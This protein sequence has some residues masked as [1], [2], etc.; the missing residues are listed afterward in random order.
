MSDVAL[1]WVIVDG[2]AR[3]VSEFAHIPVRRRPQARCPECDRPLTLKLGDVRRHHAAHAPD[4]I[5]AATQPETARHIAAKFGLAERLR[6]A[7][8][9]S[10]VLRIVQHCAGG[11]ANSDAC[12]K[13]N[14]VDWLNGWDEVQVER[15]VSETLRPDIVLQRTG[16]DVGAI[17]LLVTHAVPAEKIVAL[18]A[19]GIPWIEVDARD[20]FDVAAWTPTQSLAVLRAGS[21]APWRCMAHAAEYRTHTDVRMR[22]HAEEREAGRH[23]VVLRAARVVD[24]YHEDGVRERNIYRV[25]ALFTDGRLQGTRLMRGGFEVDSVPLTS[26][27]EWSATGWPRLRD[28]YAADV[29]R[30]SRGGRSLVDSPMRWARGDAAENIVHEAVFDRVGLDPTPLATRFPR[31]WFFVRARGEWFLPPDMRGVRWDRPDPDAFAA[32]P[33]WSRARAAVRERPAPQGSWDTPVFA[34]RPIA[35]MFVECVSAVTRPG[36]AGGRTGGGTPIAVIDIACTDAQR[37]C[38]LVVIERRAEDTEISSIT[39]ALSRDDCEQLWISHPQDWSHALTDLAWAPAGRDA[40]G[41]GGVVVDGVGVFG[42]DQFIRALA[43]GDRRLRTE[44]IQAQMADRVSRLR[45]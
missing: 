5:C 43:K 27:I 39:A 7:A 26:D 2:A 1:S 18:A 6:D 38:A 40:R 20:D 25:E 8:S 17:E 12:T 30:C 3:R 14:E 21:E 34:S 45:K 16:C 10:A 13:V 9:P 31:R 36:D 29:T 4:V 35:A 41:R 11:A 28:A 15:R 42:A 22:Q 19:L 32:H 33:A 23:G 44:A 37:R 24:V